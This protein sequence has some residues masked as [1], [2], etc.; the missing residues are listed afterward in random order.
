MTSIH[1]TGHSA[2]VHHTHAPA[3]GQGTSA[4]HS[5]HEE[6]P[7]MAGDC[8]LHGTG[9]LP[10]LDG[11]DAGDGLG[12]AQCQLED[13]Y[14]DIL[15]RPADKWARENYGQVMETGLASRE[16]I[17]QTLMG[18]LECRLRFNDTFKKLT[19]APPSKADYEALK[20]LMTSGASFDEACRELAEGGTGAESESEGLPREEAAAVYRG[21]FEE[22]LGRT[23]DTSVDDDYLQTLMSGLMTPEELRRAVMDSAEYKNRQAAE[24]IGRR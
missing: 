23:P 6:R 5:A 7:H 2:P 22:L 3:A 11:H 1:R 21:L 19:G 9:E 24:E 4:S 17:Q 18:S 16:E 15:G 14:Q 8:P 13:M 20:Q 12:D 10:A